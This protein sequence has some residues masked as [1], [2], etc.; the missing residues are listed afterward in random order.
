MGAFE[1]QG[2]H[3]SVAAGRLR[4]AGLLHHLLDASAHDALLPHPVRGASWETFVIEDILRRD[5]VAH[6]GSQAWFWR[7]ASGADL[8]RPTPCVAR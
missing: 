4:D 8:A 1:L 5:A 7:T 2:M 6:P 3:P